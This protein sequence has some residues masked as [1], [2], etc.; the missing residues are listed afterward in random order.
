MQTALKEF[1]DAFPTHEVAFKPR[2][3]G[4]LLMTL[5]QP[6]QVPLVQAIDQGRLLEPT[7]MRELIHDVRLGLRRANGEEVHVD[8]CKGWCP[9]ELPT[10]T[11]EPI[12]VRAVHSL[13][14]RGKSRGASP[15]ALHC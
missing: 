12:R 9:S 7:R 3:D 10:F 6:G 2:P 14:Y 5:R 13:V 8:D 4:T 11:G 1:C 15:Q